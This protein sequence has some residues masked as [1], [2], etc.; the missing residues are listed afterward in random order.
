MHV[1]LNTL[2][3][4]AQFV[5]SLAE[6][7][8]PDKAAEFILPGLTR[9]IGCDTATYQKLSPEPNKLGPYV[10]YP[11]GSLD[12]AALPVFEA[13]L[14]EHPLVQ[15]GLV[16]SGRGPARISEVAGRRRFR[17]L[18]IYNEY[19]RHIP[20][21][22]QIAFTLPGP[23]DG[24]LI[25]VAL[26]RSD[27]EFS[28]AD[29][30]LLRSVMPAMRNALRRSRRQRH[31]RAAVAAGHDDTLADLTDRELEVLQMAARG[32]TN[33]AIARA[34]DVSP[35]TVAKHLEHA[36]RKLGVTSRAAAVYRTAEAAEAADRGQAA[37]ARPA[38]AADRHDDRG[39]H[40][41]MFHWKPSTGRCSSSTASPTSTSRTGRTRSP[42]SCYLA[43][44]RWW[45]RI[46]SHITRSRAR[47]INLPITPSIPPGPW[48]RPN[49]RHSRPIWMSIRCSPTSATRATPSRSR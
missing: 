40:T 38:R 23:R 18:A 21:D 14:E 45:A 17:Q 3:R 2:D 22:D 9:L 4:A 7:D 48:I 25:G 5:D 44:P 29:S 43:W 20:T 36:Y 33:R 8:Q 42:N 37:L 19:F 1:S 10:E 24:K 34:L 28:A 27:E 47:R 32:R 16:I 31:A 12:P 30:A 13:H 41:W 46:S 15:H 26:S 35:R 39:A 49:S 11:T 6:L